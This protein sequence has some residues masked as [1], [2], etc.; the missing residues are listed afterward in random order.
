MIFSRTNIDGSRP[1]PWLRRLAVALILFAIVAFNFLNIFLTVR[2][3]SCH[4]QQ[5]QAINNISI[6]VSAA[7]GAYDKIF[8]G[9]RS[10]ESSEVGVLLQQARKQA[11]LMR[12]L[13]EERLLHRVFSLS[14]FKGSLEDVVK[15]LDVLILSSRDTLRAVAAGGDR[16]VFGVAANGEFNRTNESIKKSNTLL[17]QAITREQGFLFKVQIF[18]TLLSITMALFTIYYLYRYNQARKRS[19]ETKAE[20]RSQEQFLVQFSRFCRDTVAIEPV[21]EL[22]TSWLSG[23]LGID[24]VSIWRFGEGGATLSCCCLYELGS[25][26]F[27]SVGNELSCGAIPHYSAALRRDE[28]IVAEDAQTHPATGELTELY[29]LPHDIRSIL[30]IP[31]K[32][33]GEIDGVLCLEVRE[34]KRKWEPQEIALCS[35]VADQI[36]LAM[37]RTWERENR[38]KEQAANAARLEYEVRE[39]TTALAAANESL[40]EN[41]A[42][43]QLIFSK[44]PFGAALVDLYGH[45]VK[46]NEEFLRFTGYTEAELATVNFLRIVHAEGKEH[47]EENFSFLLS[48]SISKFKID[49]LYRQ[50]NGESIWGRTTIRILRGESGNPLYFLVLVEDLSERKSSEDQ[51]GKLYKAIEQSPLSI[52]ITDAS[53]NIEYANPFFCSV[54][55]YELAEVVGKNPRVLKSDTHDPAF[56]QNLWQTVNAGKTWQ[57]E[58]CNRKKDGS[59]FWEHAFIAPVTDKD[60]K[61]VSI[62]AVK[63]D[64]SERK[65]LTD[66][67]R[68]R[69]EMIASIATAALS[70][71]IMIDN[72][73]LISFW[74]KAAEKIF[75]WSRDEV[76]GVDLH[77]LI[78][79]DD[80]QKKFLANF[81]HFRQSGTGP[82]V[83]RQVELTAI[84]RNSEEFPVEISLSAIRIKG[85]WHAV[86]IVNDISERKD[87]QKNILIARDEAEAANQAKSD[88]LARMSHEIRTPMNAIIGLSDLALEMELSPKLQD[89]LGKISS[90]GK[91]L[92]YII[93]DILDFSKI[94]AKKLEIESHSFSLEKI[95]A[96]LAGVTTLKAEEKGIEFMFSVAP[97]VPD[98]L[99]GDSLR[100][101]QV[102]INLTSNAIK[103][104]QKGEVILYIA[105][106]DRSPERLTLRFSVRDTGMGLTED[107]IG[108]LFT[109]FSQADG[110]ISRNYGGTGLGLAICKRLVDLMGGGF[111]VQSRPGQGSTFSFTAVFASHPNALES[112]SFPVELQGLRVLV[113]EDNPATREILHKALDS[114][115]FLTTVVESGEKGIEEFRRAARAETPFDFLLLDY[116]LPGIN[117]DGVA[118]AVREMQED[119]K[120]PKILVLTSVGAAKIVETCIDAGCD[121][122]IDKPV[123]RSGLFNAIIRL[124]GQENSAG[125]TGSAESEKNDVLR[126][127]AGT[128]I[129]V[130]E[131]N[132][133]NQE[134]AR[135]VLQ[136]AGVL[137]DIA[138]T[139]EEALGLVVK[140]EYDLVL[141]DIQMPGMDG[142]ETTGKIRASGIKRL[143]A[144]PIVAMTAHAIKGDAE[145]SL[146][147]GMNDHITKP[148]NPKVLFATI[149]KWL[150]PDSRPTVLSPP[151]EALPMLSSDAELSGQVSG[152]DQRLALERLGSVDLYKSVLFQFCE[153]YSAAADTIIDEMRSRHW[154]EAR[155]RLHS[156]K[157]VVGTI[158]AKELYDITVYL[159][160]NCKEQQLHPERLLAFKELY[161]KLINELQSFFSSASTLA[162]QAEEEVDRER[163][164]EIFTVMLS[165]IQAHRPVHCAGH[166]ENLKKLNWPAVIT[167]EMQSLVSAV[168]SYQFKQA[169]KLVQKVCQI[170]EV[171]GQS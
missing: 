81:D 121:A 120:Q 27:L 9:D 145:L 1:S 28:P 61:I 167:A 108:N 3:T 14:E 116:L 122:V 29:L 60:G 46:V 6:S 147:A 160:K 21:Y 155:L 7:H 165:D 59:L 126:M 159:E 133:I 86:G 146:A 114:Y 134:V 45:F 91:N 109:P 62:I 103:F 144:L 54:T 73:G 30:D 33:N 151:Q 80:D 47:Y 43:L 51:L 118:R 26:Q 149:G 100:L 53:G 96:D 90:S 98:R 85:E 163:L 97:D 68:E 12:E 113:V 56:Y 57:G 161:D 83:G 117:G 23:H 63:E 36:S 67:L 111:E 24:R 74:N 132:Q 65:Q 171:E 130:V 11:V 55:G 40:R 153:N 136:R 148:I 123:S 41:E 76:L 162:P 131:D 10:L 71:I 119:V 70:A 110:S 166:V 48:G 19:L 75:G 140:N 112:H 150:A 31:L 50:K 16:L 138:N 105:M 66:E 129:L 99:I 104:T 128:K 79:S 34:K 157:G 64:I 115:S 69:S 32:L 17:W 143:A 107:Q 35:G 139:G 124:Y 4:N 88:F 156:L 125:A 135:E 18:L 137:V 49:T 52:V 72:R 15:Q 82:V 169:G 2:L 5:L 8:T 93:N 20:Q 22:V 37:G 89:Y 102:L 39:R 106:V 13:G 42:Q 164:L 141:M 154:E 94:E 78:V 170:L 95:L 101:G 92:L 58:I 84:R 77:Q 168:E 158:C 142:L 152:L 127:L 87:A 38:E 44:A 25:K